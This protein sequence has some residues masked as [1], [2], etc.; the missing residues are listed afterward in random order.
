MPIGLADGNHVGNDRQI[1]ND[2]GH[3][4]LLCKVLRVSWM[5]QPVLSVS[6]WTLTV[7]INP[8]AVLFRVVTLNGLSE[9]PVLPFL[10]RSLSLFYS[11]FQDYPAICGH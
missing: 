5:P 2:K 1:R 9:R 8:A 6:A 10:W 4:L 7:C 11:V 3:S